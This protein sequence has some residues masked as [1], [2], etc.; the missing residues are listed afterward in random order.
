VSDGAVGSDETVD[1]A[2]RDGGVATPADGRPGETIARRSSRWR[3]TTV[4]VLFGDAT[5]LTLFLSAVVFLVATWR[6]GTFFNDVDLFVPALRQFADGRLALGPPGDIA[7]YYPG[8]YYH[9]GLVYARNYGQLAASLPAYWVARALGPIA[10]RGLVVLGWSVLVVVVT[11]RIGRRYDHRRTGLAVGGAVASVVLLANH[12]AFEPLAAGEAAIIALQSTSVLFGAFTGVLLYRLLARRHGTRVGVAAGAVTVLAS[13]VG[14]WATVPKRHAFAAFLVT[15][16]LYGLVRSRGVDAE[17][18]LGQAGFRSVA[19]ASAGLLSWIHAPEGFT[20]FLAVAVVDLPTATRND[21]RTLGVLAVAVA[22]SLLP[23]A[24]TNFT[25]S[26]VPIRP[27]RFLHS[28]GSGDALDA[29]AAR[30]SDAGAGPSAA[31]GGGSAGSS[32]SN[33]G[34]RPGGVALPV[35][36]PAEIVATVFPPGAVALLEQGLFRYVDG[37]VLAVTDFDRLSA[38]LFRWGDRGY[39][40][41]SRFFGEGTNLSV[42]ASL[43]VAAVLVARPFRDAVDAFRTRTLPS[44]ELGVGGLFAVVASALLLALYLP[45]LPVRVMVTVRYLHP[46]YPLLVYG[47]FRQ[48]AVR[49]VLTDHASDA[50]LGWAAATLLGMPAALG[51]ILVDPAVLPPSPGEVVQAYSL[52]ALAAALVVGFAF[53][54]GTENR[55]VGRAA[56]LA[57][58]VAAGVTTAFILLTSFVLFHFGPSI[59]PAVDALA[60]AYANALFA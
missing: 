55:R 36:S 28:V 23:V 16:A 59:L 27:P 12:L 50:V 38:V 31:D 8:M 7:E 21:V 2:E 5:G 42:L 58:G 43:P 44:W 11:T 48:R 10:T 51:L 9:D 30:Q 6:V 41:G 3:E 17:A 56:A 25:I 13:P 4:E 49:V 26:G 35:P 45:N 60:D 52:F 18:R 14:F 33:T 53:L 37:A 34:S 20:L 29:L 54:L 22:L 15:L 32:G 47:V 1:T 40:P 46:L 24:V 39:D 57:F 19:Y